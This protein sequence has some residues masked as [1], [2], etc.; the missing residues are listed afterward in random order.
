MTGIRR[1]TCSWGRYRSSVLS[2]TRG[3]GLMEVRLQL[4]PMN[5]GRQHNHLRSGLDSQES[6]GDVKA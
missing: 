2:S 4:H 1:V 5:L 6:L 3:D